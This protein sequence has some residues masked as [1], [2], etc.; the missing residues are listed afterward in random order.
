VTLQNCSHPAHEDI[1]RSHIEPHL[2]G[3]VRVIDAENFAIN[4]AAELQNKA[5][6][7][8]PATANAMEQNY[9]QLGNWM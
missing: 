5:K 9:G 2:H 4:V 3:D 6:V 1:W 8:N 7:A